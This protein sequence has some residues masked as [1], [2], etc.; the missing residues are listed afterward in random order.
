MTE[1][2]PRRGT[3]LRRAQRFEAKQVIFFYKL[4]VKIVSLFY[5]DQEEWKVDLGYADFQFVKT[6]S[7]I[8]VI[9]IFLVYHT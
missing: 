5:L 9:Q 3:F 8:K 4:Y 1:Y 6:S 2:N 7:N